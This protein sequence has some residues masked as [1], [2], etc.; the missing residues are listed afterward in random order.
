MANEGGEEGVVAEDG[1]HPSACIRSLEAGRVT[2]AEG[3]ACEA[4]VKRGL[5]IEA[6]IATLKTSFLAAMAKRQQ[7][8]GRLMVMD[9]E[10]EGTKARAAQDKKRARISEECEH[11]F[12][13]RAPSYMRDNGEFEYICAHC[14]C[15]DSFG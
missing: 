11:Y 15:R 10:P 13:R 14:G 2:E 6:E 4:Y 9:D 3:H 12:L 7:W 5:E 8:M 1:V